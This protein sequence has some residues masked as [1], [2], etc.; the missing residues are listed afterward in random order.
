MMNSSRQWQ[1]RRQ[2]YME[3]WGESYKWFSIRPR[4]WV[5]RHHEEPRINRDIDID[6]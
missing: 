2:R 5:L 1:R 6:W 3:D 4:N